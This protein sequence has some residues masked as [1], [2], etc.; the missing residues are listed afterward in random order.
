MD[1]AC[2]PL[3]GNAGNL[4]ARF[5]TTS[6]APILFNEGGDID[7]LGRGWIWEGQLLKCSHQNHVFR[8]RL[9]VPSEQSKI[10]S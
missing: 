10:I 3:D 7:K 4:S 1:P 8:A 2:P 5:P 9:F 6:H